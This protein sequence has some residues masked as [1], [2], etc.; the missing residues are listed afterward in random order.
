M[1]LSEAASI[2]MTT[3][4]CPYLAS[5][6]DTE[7]ALWIALSTASFKSPGVQR[8]D[9]EYRAIYRERHSI[10]SMSS[11][12]IRGN[13]LWFPKFP[14]RARRSLLQQPWNS[15]IAVLLLGMFIGPAYG[16]AQSAP[17]TATKPWFS[18]EERNFAGKAKSRTETQLTFDAEKT[19]S[20][21]E[22]IDLAEQHN[23]DTRAAWQ[24]AKTRAAELGVAKGALYPALAAIALAGT[25]RHGELIGNWTIQTIGVFRPTLNI[26][27]LIF[28][29]GGRSGAIAAARANLFASNF[30]F[31]DTHRKII[32]DVMLTY[33]RLLDAIG[34]QDAAKASL[35]NA[36]A[37][38]KD[39]A[40]RLDHG[41]ATNPDVLEAIATR[42]HAEYELADVLGAQE[43]AQGD[44]AT[45]L[46][47]P[48]DTVIA[49]QGMDNIATPTH[50]AEAADQMIDRAFEQR[51]D[52]MERVAH[53]REAEAELE[54][55]KSVYLPSLSFSSALGKER[56]YGQQGDLPGSFAT[57]PE[58]WKVELGLK[59][60]I[61]DGGRR[62]SEVA[63]AKARR[64]RAQ[65]EIDA[66][67]DRIE[68]EVW[69]AYTSAKTA[70]R[71]QE[72]ASA[73]LLASDQSYTAA[74]RA[75]DL[76]VRNLLDVL[77]AQ[78]ALAEART[79]DVTA[80]TEVLS[81][82][83]NLA[84]TTAD[85]LILPAAHPHP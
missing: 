77:A 48:A 16:I 65:A 7:H 49:V 40:D 9:P 36:R 19:Y 10:M 53:L 69:R 57:V 13:D 78:R 63:E 34:R 1:P 42:A 51:P 32:Y 67:R 46:G 84:F 18:G 74:L 43:I 6:S 80:H 11:T 68:D 30:A 75:C 76:G 28:D 50:L 82:V 37:V 33:Y 44:L 3:S 15:A 83:A 81:Q 21:A 61:F 12:C 26:E 24:A 31:N 60:T 38:E 72:A 52:L 56:A 47:L 5:S 14:G 45:V 54:Q 27:Y 64:N 58:Y 79:A 4:K 66:L 39:A 59:W 17:S 73:Q 25:N 29:F 71:Q 20:L 41:L 8:C 23:P 35:A 85:L 22:L 2:Y 55:A 70:F 62:E